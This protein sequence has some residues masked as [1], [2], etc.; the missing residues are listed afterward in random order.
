M[1]NGGRFTDDQVDQLR[2]LGSW[3]VNSEVVHL[4]VKKIIEQ[5]SD[6]AGLIYSGRYM[7]LKL[8]M[9]IRERYRLWLVCTPCWEEQVEEWKL[10]L[11]IFINAFC[12]QSTRIGL[13]K[14][15]LDIAGKS[16]LKFLPLTCGHLKGMGRTEVV[17]LQE[18]VQGEHT[19]SNKSF[20]IGLAAEDEVFSRVN[21]ANSN[22]LPCFA[23]SL[24]QLDTAQDFQRAK[25]TCTWKH[26]HQEW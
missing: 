15:S 26:W 21:I 14:N 25:K 2:R 6:S 24:Q 8:H 4:Y 23:G 17:P 5:Y 16:V 10:Q 3:S 18:E 12:E 22:L 13:L 9:P 20:S 7:S 11:V 1:E 19:K